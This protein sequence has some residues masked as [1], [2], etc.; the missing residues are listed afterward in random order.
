MRACRELS[1]EKSRDYIMSD[2]CFMTG[3][4]YRQIIFLQFCESQRGR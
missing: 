3:R 1:N 2:Y 4:D